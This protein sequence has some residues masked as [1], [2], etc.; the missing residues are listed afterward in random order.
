VEAAV[1]VLSKL[2]RAGLFAP[3]SRVVLEHAAKQPPPD[4][5]AGLLRV[6]DQ[7]RWGDTAVTLFEPVGEPAA[8][9][10]PLTP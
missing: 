1:A 5:E 10:G 4:V 7:R 8:V 2:C 3:G 9:P 6:F